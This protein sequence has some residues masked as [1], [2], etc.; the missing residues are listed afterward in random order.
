MV[1]EMAVD[2]CYYK[3]GTRHAADDPSAC[4][5]GVGED[6]PAVTYVQMMIK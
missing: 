5:V 3:R 6:V 1:S 4:L 2:P